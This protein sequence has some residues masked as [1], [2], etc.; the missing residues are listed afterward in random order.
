MELMNYVETGEHKELPSMDAEMAF[1]F[2]KNQIDIDQK[3]YDKKIESRS[4]AG[5]LGGAPE[6][7]SNAK[8]QTKQPKTSIMIMIM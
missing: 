6:G 7:N 2:I 8:K 3:K 1:L 4:E 5:K